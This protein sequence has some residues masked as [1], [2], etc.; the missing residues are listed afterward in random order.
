MPQHNPLL[1]LSADSVIE[2]DTTLE[3]NGRQQN[4]RVNKV[5]HV[6]P[7]LPHRNPSDPSFPY[8]KQDPYFANHACCLGD[9]ANP[10]TWKLA[11]PETE[12]YRKENTCVPGSLVYFAE[13]DFCRLGRG[14]ICGDGDAIPELEPTNRCGCN[15]AA[16]CADKAISF[17]LRPGAG[18]CHG[19][20]GCQSFCAKGRPV[21][22][23][24]SNG[25]AD[26]GDMCGC[27]SATQGKICDQ[28]ATNTYDGECKTLAFVSWCAGE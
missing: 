10:A 3:Y 1:P 12:C 4:A 7:C 24:N 27:T 16:E 22:D 18:W 25:I 23:V 17:G 26:Q 28:E 6:V 5:I 9:S 13:K 21:V 15:A 11:G 8:N 20:Q 14:N 19:F 2:L